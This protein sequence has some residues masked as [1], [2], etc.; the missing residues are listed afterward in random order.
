MADTQEA[1]WRDVGTLDAYWK[2]NLDLTADSPQ[3]DLHD[4]E[5]PIRTC[6]QQP[7][8]ARFLSGEGDLPGMALDSLVATGCVISG[9]TIRNSLLFRDV[10]VGANAHVDESVVLPGAQI[11]PRCRIRKSIIDASCRLP[12]GTVV[13][14]D[15]PRDGR[16]FHRTPGGVTVVS[17]DMLTNIEPSM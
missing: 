17:A 1:Y 6:Q 4:A 15:P 13:G 11:G 2:A 10:R 7:A 5:W 9:A 12:E 14:E 16:I 3:L 8:A